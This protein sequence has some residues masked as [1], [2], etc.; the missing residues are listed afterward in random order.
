VHEVRKLVEQHLAKD[1]DPL[2]KPN[3]R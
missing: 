2:S 3:G 1:L